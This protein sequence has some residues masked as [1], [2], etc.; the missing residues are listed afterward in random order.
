MCVD[1]EE[2]LLVPKKVNLSSSLL[3]S[4]ILISEVPV[5][6]HN[7]PCDALYY[8]CE[9]PGE[10]MTSVFYRGPFQNSE[11]R[12]TYVRSDLSKLLL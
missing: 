8:T 2:G 4:F 1:L 6:I 11:R 12:L 9:L 10:K 5:R 7:R 3:S